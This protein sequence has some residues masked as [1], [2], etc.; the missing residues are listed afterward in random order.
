MYQ[1]ICLHCKNNCRKNLQ[2]L[3]EIH[4]P[5]YVR[6]YTFLELKSWSPVMS[7][8]FLPLWTTIKFKKLQSTGFKQLSLVR[9][10]YLNSSCSLAET[11][12]GVTGSSIGWR[13]Y[14]WHE[15]WNS[16]R[17]RRH[18]QVTIDMNGILCTL[19]SSV[20]FFFLN[21]KNNF[22]KRK[23]WKINNNSCRSEIC[24]LCHVNLTFE[25]SF[26]RE[27]RV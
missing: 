11:L 17:W 13:W 23:N 25:F 18:G 10:W 14:A 20:F 3:V 21:Y 24:A 8:T 9:Q 6:I 26:F 22:F 27:D 15:G 2:S 4:W 19:F 16:P 12:C 5:I 7:F 1:D